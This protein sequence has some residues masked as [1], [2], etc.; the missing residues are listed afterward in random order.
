MARP[1]EISQEG[2]KDRRRAFLG[3]R[4]RQRV[5][6]ALRAERRGERSNPSELLTF[7]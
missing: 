7:L 1:C 2:Q 6:P 4:C 5:W 3:S